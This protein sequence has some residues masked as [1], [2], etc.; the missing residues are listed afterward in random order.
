MNI[1][2]KERHPGAAETIVALLHWLA[3]GMLRLCGRRGATGA[4]DANRAKGPEGH[5]APGPD[6]GSHRVWWGGP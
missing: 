6:E 4:S 2:C 3:N 5:G 1:R